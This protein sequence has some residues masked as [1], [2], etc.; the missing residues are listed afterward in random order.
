MAGPF[1]AAG[2]AEALRRLI[3]SI[4]T[5]KQSDI[6]RQDMLEEIERRQQQ[7][8]WQR[9]TTERGLGLEERRVAEAERAGPAGEALTAG[10]QALAERIA[11][12]EEAGRSTRWQQPSGAQMLPWTMGMTPAQKAEIASGESIARLPYGER[13]AESRFRFG[14]DAGALV[15][16]PGVPPGTAPGLWG[17]YPKPPAPMEGG[18]AGLPEGPIDPRTAQLMMDWLQHTTPGAGVRR[19]GGGGGEGPSLMTG[20]SIEEQ[21]LRQ[22]IRNLY[23]DRDGGEK[24]TWDPY[25]VDPE[26][27]ELGTWRRTRTRGEDPGSARYEQLTGEIQGLEARLEGGPAAGPPAVEQWPA[28]SITPAEAQQMLATGKFTREQIIAKYQVAA[29]EPRVGGATG[30]RPTGRAGPNR[31]RG[32]RRS[33]PGR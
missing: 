21:R 3:G 13:T 9:G 6:A 2:R 14:E 1:V 30:R 19:P 20:M 32:G 24:Q 26:T 8:R 33:M 27:G 5:G 16:P 31:G 22:Q 12:L 23:A 11:M 4:L 25:G 28:M 10:Q 7:E 15:P 18:F 17:E 29:I